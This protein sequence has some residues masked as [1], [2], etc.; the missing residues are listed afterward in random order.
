MGKVGSELVAFQV[1]CN[2]FVLIFVVLVGL[3]FFS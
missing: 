1:N 2:G 3:G